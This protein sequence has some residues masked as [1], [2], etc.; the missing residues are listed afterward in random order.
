MPTPANSTVGASAPLHLVDDAPLRP[1][2]DF[3][4]QKLG[5]EQGAVLDATRTEGK[6]VDGAHGRPDS[7]TVAHI[8]DHEHRLLGRLVDCAF[9]RTASF[10][11]SLEPKSGVV[12]EHGT[13]VVNEHGTAPFLGSHWSVSSS[14]WP[15]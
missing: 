7:K 15:F 6:L 10:S 4:R 5:I 8:R 14:L 9:G 13:H 1:R 3:F 11:G 12:N 2:P